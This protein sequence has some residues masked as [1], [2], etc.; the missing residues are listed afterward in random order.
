M[1]SF[2]KNLKFILEENFTLPPLTG[3]E[4]RS[5][6]GTLTGNAK[7][8]FKWVFNPS[9]SRKTALPVQLQAAEKPASVREMLAPL[10]SGASPP[11]ATKGTGS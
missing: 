3:K 5:I 9:N 10:L 11:G 6:K 1:N 2:F 4:R 8:N 7:R